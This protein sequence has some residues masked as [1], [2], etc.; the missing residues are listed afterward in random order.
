MRTSEFSNALP[1]VPQTPQE[2]TRLLMGQV[3]SQAAQGE[4]NRIL[5]LALEVRLRN[6]SYRS[7]SMGSMRLARWAGMRPAAA[8][9]TV[10]SS[11]VPT[12]IPG[13]YG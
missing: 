8:D 4:L 10:R 5:G 6:Y 11:I 3:R 13:S 2:A 9:T 12:A 7:A 1:F